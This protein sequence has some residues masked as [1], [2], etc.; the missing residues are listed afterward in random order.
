MARILQLNTVRD[1]NDYLGVET[2]N[3]LVNVI[4]ASKI[5]PMRRYPQYFSR[6]FKKAVGCTPKE[7]RMS[8]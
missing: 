7:Y 6:A 1:Y 8:Q 3:P 5:G 4:D 2:R